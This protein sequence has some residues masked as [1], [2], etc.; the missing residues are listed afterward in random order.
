[1][2]W[3]HLEY[4]LGLFGANVVPTARCQINMPILQLEKMESRFSDSEQLALTEAA[5]GPARNQ[6]SHILST[7]PYHGLLRLRGGIPF[8]Y[9]SYLRSSQELL[10]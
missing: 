5:R 8:A 1:M 10:W 2:A 3:P 4:L 7:L 6:S 9:H